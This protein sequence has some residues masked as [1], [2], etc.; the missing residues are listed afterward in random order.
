VSIDVTDELVERI[1]RLSRLAIS[2][3]EAASLR[4]H[5]EKVLAYVAEL[6]ALDTRDVDP[7]HFALDARNVDRED[8][9]RPSL[10]VAEALKNAPQAS[11][12]YFAVPRIVGDEEGA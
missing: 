3:D 2:P 9:A 11:G 4:Q 1:A 5:F 10:P 12:P 7:S 8:V 6:Q